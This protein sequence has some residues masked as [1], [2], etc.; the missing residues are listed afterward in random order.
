MAMGHNLRLMRGI[1]RRLNVDLRITKYE[2][3]MWVCHKIRLRSRRLEIVKIV[4][5]FRA[6]NHRVS[7]IVDDYDVGC[8]EVVE[9]RM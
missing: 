5:G 1:F 6:R 7:R 2:V 8:F 3:H 4:P 9:Q